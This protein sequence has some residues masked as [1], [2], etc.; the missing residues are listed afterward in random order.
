MSL[1]PE[2]PFQPL[3]NVRK[4][5]EQMFATSPLEMNFFNQ[6]LGNLGGMMGINVQ[7]TATEVIATCQ[8][9]GLQKGD[10]IQIHVDPHL[11]TIRGS[12]DTRFEK[13]DEN[14]YKQQ[15]FASSFHR[16]ISLPSPVSRDGVKASY[17]ND[18][19]EVIMQ[20]T[21]DHNVHSSIDIDFY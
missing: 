11:L 8:I 10:D 4:D 12:I 5:I 6:L 13:K 20:K 1:L 15:R 2:D 9:P 16:A 7:E 18:V 19:L 17:Q 21:S 14:L 3:M